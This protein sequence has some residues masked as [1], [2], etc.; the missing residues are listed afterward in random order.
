MELYISDIDVCEKMLKELNQIRG[1]NP[2][3]I[4]FFDYPDNKE[5]S[6]SFEFLYKDNIRIIY[7]DKKFKVEFYE[8]KPPHSRYI[9]TEQLDI[10]MS[11]LAVFSELTLDDID[12]TSW[13]SVLW[14]PVKSTT[15]QQ[16]MNTTF[17]VYYQFEYTEDSSYYRDQ[18]NNYEEIPIVGILPIKFEDGLW[19]TRISKSNSYII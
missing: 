14:S 9:L 4:R 1:E 17:L 13:F 19:L 2:G 7:L 16:F 11:S 15:K 6:S 3:D 5:G 18:F 12:K 10:A 8:T